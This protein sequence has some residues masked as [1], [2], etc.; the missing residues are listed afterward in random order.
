MAPSKIKDGI[1]KHE[2]TT[3]GDCPRGVNGNTSAL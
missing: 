2:T 1:E 3:P